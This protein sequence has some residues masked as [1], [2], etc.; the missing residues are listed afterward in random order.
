MSV[1]DLKLPNYYL[2]NN[3]RFHNFSFLRDEN[4]FIFFIDVINKSIL[5]K[6]SVITWHF[7]RTCNDV[8]ENAHDRK[9]H[10][11]FSRNGNL[12]PN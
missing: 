6:H 5:G 3:V 10:R 11:I 1:S 4:S 7:P 2:E 9:R 12:L 8:I